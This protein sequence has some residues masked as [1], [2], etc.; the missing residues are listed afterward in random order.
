MTTLTGN[1][2][3]DFHQ[4]AARIAAADRRDQAVD[5]LIGRV[6][7][8]ATGASIGLLAGMAAAWPW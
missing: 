2:A 6:L 8:F 3:Y 7:F 4:L 1:H 5:K